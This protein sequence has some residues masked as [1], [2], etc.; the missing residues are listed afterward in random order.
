[1]SCARLKS[2]A[3][4]NSV[5]FFGSFCLLIKTPCG[6]PEFSTGGSTTAIESSS[7]NKR[8]RTVRRWNSSRLSCTVCLKYPLNRKTFVRREPVPLYRMLHGLAGMKLS[9][10]LCGDA[11]LHKEGLDRRLRRVTILPQTS[12]AEWRVFQDR[13]LRLGSAELRNR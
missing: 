3:L 2:E 4:K 6:I 7:K 1:M 13:F 8:I 9:S 11:C 12:Y 5:E 10:P